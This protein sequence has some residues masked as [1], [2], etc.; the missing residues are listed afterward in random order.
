MGKNRNIL[1][2]TGTDYTELFK[3]KSA[4][5]RGLLIVKHRA[6]L[7]FETE[8]SSKRKGT[9]TIQFLIIKWFSVF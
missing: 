3:C 6:G 1:Y 8:K 4:R 9:R 2:K 7:A 5:V